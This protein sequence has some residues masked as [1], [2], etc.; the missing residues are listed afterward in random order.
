MT[1]VPT[2]ETSHGGT[3]PIRCSIEA[4]F[5]ALE[6]PLLG[7]AFRL[8]QSGDL[9][10]DLVQEAFLRLHH[11][12]ES[13]R[14][15]KP[16]LFQT[17]HHLAVSHIRKSSR[18]RQLGATKEGVDASMDPSGNPYQ[19]PDE[20]IAHQEA[21]G[22]VRLT[23]DGMDEQSRQLIQL[24]F[25][26]EKSYKEISAIMG[27]TPGHVGYLLHHAMKSMAQELKQAGLQ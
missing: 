27:L 8:V 3:D 18:L 21:L 7:Y 10:Q 24:K 13:V 4:L 25:E 17:V 14:E 16:W 12:W 11:H 23:L 19:L 2:S 9:A 22:L 6:T 20:W 15:P 1:I 5:E 26:E